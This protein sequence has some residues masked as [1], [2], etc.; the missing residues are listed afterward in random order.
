MKNPY[1]SRDIL[2]AVLMILDKETFIMVL[3]A[4]PL[5]MKLSSYANTLFCTWL[6]NGKVLLKI[7]GV[8][9]DEEL[10]SVN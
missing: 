8:S 3:Q 4:Y 10:C 6:L 2:A 5:G 7:F 9:K 1:L